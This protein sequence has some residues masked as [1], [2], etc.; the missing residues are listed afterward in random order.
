[1]ISCRY[2]GSHACHVGILPRPLPVRGPFIGRHLIKSI[3]VLRVRDFFADLLDEVLGRLLLICEYVGLR[4]CPGFVGNAR[5]HGFF[6]TKPWPVPVQL[7][8]T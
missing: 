6:N 4:V 1:M 2:S 7:V 8:K 5:V 3:E